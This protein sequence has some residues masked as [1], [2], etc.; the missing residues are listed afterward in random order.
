MVIVTA[1][2]VLSRPASHERTYISYVS[3]ESD[4]KGSRLAARTKVFR[5]CGL[6]VAGIGGDVLAESEQPAQGLIDADGGDEAAR[7]QRPVGNVRDAGLGAVGQGRIVWFVEVK[8]VL[9]GG[10]RRHLQARRICSAVTLDRPIEAIFP[11]AW[12]AAS[13]PTWS[14]SGTAG[15]IRCR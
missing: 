4:K 2:I 7:V 12:R 11:S 1:S 14:A 6:L 13:S 5:C 3:R 15:S 9:Y 10:D 8:A